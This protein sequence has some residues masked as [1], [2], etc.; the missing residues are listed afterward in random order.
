MNLLEGPERLKAI[1]FIEKSTKDA[2]ALLN[3]IT[4]ENI[5][6]NLRKR[7][8]L[9]HKI[10]NQKRWLHGA[11]RDESKYEKHDYRIKLTREIVLN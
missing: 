10:Q 9:M 1:E 6:E 8:L 5:E 11:S 7:S 2:D 4:A 3:T